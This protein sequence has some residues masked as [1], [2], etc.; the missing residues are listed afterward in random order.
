[1]TSGPT[2]CLLTAASVDGREPIDI[3]IDGGRIEAMA[4]R[5]PRQGERIIDCGG[6]AVLPGL[7]DHHVHLFALA[8]ALDSVQ[9]GPPQ[10]HTAD[11]LGQALAAGSDLGDGWIRGVGYHESVA[12]ELDAPRLDRLVARRPVRVQHRSGAFWALNSEALR[13]LAIAEREVEGI[14]RD[15]AGSPTGRLWRLDDWLR[16]QL[17][18]AQPPDVAAASGLLARRGVTGIT[19]ATPG[20]AANVFG[21]G[22]LLQRLTVMAT[23]AR[24]GSTLGPLKIRPSDHTDPDLAGLATTIRVVRPRPVAIHCVTRVGLLVAL[25]ALQDVGAVTGDRIEHAAI[26]PPEARPWL[27]QLGLTVVTQPSLIASRGDD[28]LDDVD[29]DDRAN[30]WPLH[31]L[32]DAGI[33]VGLSSDAPYGWADPWATMQAAI[34]RTAPSGR[35]VGSDERVDAS[36]ALRG[37]LT[38]A[39]DPGGAARVIAPG[40]VADLIVLDRSLAEA[41]RR[42]SAVEVEVTLIGGRV[43]HESA[44]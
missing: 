9:C 5:L 38:A 1:M 11:E 40:H 29:A 33:P 23:E 25:T 13:R 16:Q 14:E 41:H 18:P 3:R 27:K 7:H 22:P 32:L 12:G 39:H 24:P 36:V 28:Y 30:L 10:V 2:R 35:I 8:R 19:D 31:S 17:G 34:D 6:H 43:V 26:V 20:P 37:F 4:G 42:P 44:A 21:D 15:A